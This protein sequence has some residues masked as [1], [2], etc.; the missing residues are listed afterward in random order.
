MQALPLW[1]TLFYT[2]QWAQHRDSKDELKELCQQLEQQKHVSNVSNSVKHGLYESGFDFVEQPGEAVRAWSDWVKHCMFQASAR[3]N[4]RYWP[5]GLNVDVELHESWCH[6]T[7]DGGYHDTHI[8]ANSAWSCI[9]YLDIGD[10]DIDTKNGV[11]RFY[12][13]T[14]TMYSDAGTLYATED[15]SIDISPQE[16]MMV[17]FPSWIQHSALVYRGQQDRYILSAN[18][19]VK[20]SA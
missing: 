8:H 1:P 20:V 9:Y 18:C 4:Q 17:V 7:R 11:N 5:A 3:A 10:M 12:N 14:A 2:F 15:S 16:G 13:P 6:I 19:R